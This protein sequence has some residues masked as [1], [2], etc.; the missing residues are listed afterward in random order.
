MLHLANDLDPRLLGERFE[1]IRRIA[2]SIGSGERVVLFCSTAASEVRCLAV[3]V[4][5]EKTQIVR[6]VVEEVAVDVVD[7]Q[8]QR[9]AVVDGSATAPCA[10]FGYADVGKSRP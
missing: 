2:L 8:D 6:S 3:T 1:L 7:M 4:G 9:P 5:A 10:V